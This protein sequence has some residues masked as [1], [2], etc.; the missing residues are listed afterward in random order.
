MK[1]YG[2]YAG[3]S[4]GQNFKKGRFNMDIME[5][6]IEL[7]KMIQDSEEMKALKKA[8]ELQQNDE[9][10]AGLIQEYNLKRMNI[11]RDMDAK[12]ITEQEAIK[13]DK[14]AYD[15]LLKNDLIAGYIKAKE[16]F[17]NLVQRIN[18]VLTYYITGEEPGCS[19]NCGSCGG[20]C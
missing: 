12:K 11:V 20:C 4:C 13:A 6:T 17:N 19:H 1:S 18:D 3:E 16:E 8:E 10:A 2:K 9:E 15:A 5:K 7:G 14:E